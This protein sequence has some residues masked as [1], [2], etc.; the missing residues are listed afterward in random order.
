[1]LTGLTGQT[2]KEG[3]MKL[4]NTLIKMFSLVFAVCAAFAIATMPTAKTVNAQEEASFKTNES[5][6]LVYEGEDE[7]KVGLKFEAE[8]NTAWLSAN[9]AE[10]YTFG[11]IVAPTANFTAW[12]GD[13]APTANMEAVDGVN[14]IRI[15]NS[16][17]S[18]GATFGA[19]ILFDDESLKA[20]IA[21]KLE[22]EVADVT[23]EQ[24]ANLKEE[25]YVQSYSA[26]AYATFGEEIVYLDKV[27][28]SMREAAI[29][30]LPS[31]IANEDFNVVN[32]ALTFIGITEDDMYDASAYVDG[33]KLVVDGGDEFT[34]EESDVIVA[35]DKVLKL[36]AGYSLDNGVVSFD[37][38]DNT[39]T[40][41]Y[42]IKDTSIIGMEI[43]YPDVVLADKDD[44]VDFFTNKEKM[45]YSEAN[46]AHYNTKTAV[47]AN[48]IDLEG[49]I[50]HNYTS[51]YF[52][53]T[54]DGRGHVLSNLTVQTI[55]PD[56]KKNTSYGL[57]GNIQ[58]DGIIRNVAFS[59]AKTVDHQA[60]GSLIAYGFSGLM[61]N[62]YLS[63]SVDNQSRSGMF[64]LAEKGL[65]RN[66][67]IV[68]NYYD[69]NF[70]VD[71]YI[72][73]NNSAWGVSPIVR[74]MSEKS[75]TF[76]NVQVISRK[77]LSYVSNGSNVFEVTYT[78]PVVDDPETTDKDETAPAK[79]NWGARFAYA[80]NE[81]ELWYDFEYFYNEA[82]TNE[83]GFS[84]GLGLEAGTANV[85]NTLETGKTIRYSGI[86]RYDDMAALM[87]D[88]ANNSNKD[89]LLNS[90]FWKVVDD[91][92]VW[93]N[94]A[95]IAAPCA[96]VNEVDYDAST[97]I[98][99]TTAWNGET[100]EKITI[101]G[102]VLTAEENGGLVLDN[103]QNIIGIRA[104]VSANDEI[105]GIDYKTNYNNASNVIKYDG[106]LRVYT[107]NQVYAIRNINYYTQ[108]IFDATDL[109]E[110][111]GYNVDYSVVDL[112]AEDSETERELAVDGK[113]GYIVA[114]T[115]YS[116]K[117]YEAVYNVGIYKMMN[118]VDMEKTSIGYTNNTIVMGD[119]IGGFV[120]RFDGN[121][122]AIQNYK[123][124][125]QGL[126]GRMSNTVSGNEVKTSERYFKS[127]AK[128]ENLAIIDV[129]TTY[130]DETQLQE[131][132]ILA[133]TAGH[134]SYTAGYSDTII[135]NIYVTV[136]SESTALGNFITQIGGN[137]KINNLY[138]VNTN[139]FGMEAQDNNKFRLTDDPSRASATIASD[140]K[141]YNLFTNYGKNVK[142]LEGVLF[143]HAYTN[144]SNAPAQTWEVIQ[145]SLDDITNTHVVTTMP[146]SYFTYGTPFA[147]TY[148]N[149]YLC[150]KTDAEKGVVLPKEDLYKL[151]QVSVTEGKAYMAIAYAANETVGNIPVMYGIKQSV[152]D[153]VK[154]AYAATSTIPPN[155]SNTAFM[156]DTCGEIA[157]NLTGH[158]TVK[159]G[160][161]CCYTYSDVACTGKFVAAADYKVP[162]STG[163]FNTPVLYTFT[164]HTSADMGEYYS[165]SN[166]AYKLKNVKKYADAQAMKAANNDYSSFTGETGNGLWEVVE[167]ELIWVGRVA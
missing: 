154:A 80:E 106:T 151:G 135:N 121:G 36:G 131:T 158:R 150:V 108:L 12:D 118:N 6:I 11:M 50:F 136:S 129:I 81:T 46:K 91:E 123:A 52:S 104:K 78:D 124:D 101:N 114:T 8:F 159:A 24:L 70:S 117:Y 125:Q 40:F 45:I 9:P 127:A 26:V 42:V 51:V 56:A 71:D 146:I 47:L 122:Y 83:Y 64:V 25:V 49:V 107:D 43:D 145:G 84:L 33:N 7:G 130:W 126:F 89:S 138:L 82:G 96:F 21:E 142:N 30:V 61:E 133:L 19:S 22:I 88:E 59:D 13:V 165:H 74:S 162:G 103:E 141:I 44:V 38:V 1:M 2:I 48:D 31:A 137:V 35:N 58:E 15:Q 39:A 115:K 87:A 93:A 99:Y 72:V 34:F 156:C 166:G 68:D 29:S 143:G 69:P 14:I 109:R 120:A 147:Y 60:N 152:I 53:G 98:L 4:R 92:I 148:T 119:K 94:D 116:N 157:F 63:Y 140:A 32:V 105:V 132:P 144:V 10:K 77:P 97:G 28:T 79:M 23:P 16:Q 100:V 95:N 27:D 57:F 111:V 41:I 3:V 164:Y 86:R 55:D 155:N 134:D 17:L 75:S 153:D 66:M 5:S 102:V 20:T 85:E 18:A 67:V 139:E 62:V 113:K 163:Q 161:A 128:I 160:T 65:M 90:G 54:F 73:E 112:G 37:E 149:S 110:A 167:G 76:E